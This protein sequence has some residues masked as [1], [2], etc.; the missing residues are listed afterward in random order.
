M[1]TTNAEVMTRLNEVLDE[2]QAG[3]RLE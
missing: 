2:I 1:M 3:W